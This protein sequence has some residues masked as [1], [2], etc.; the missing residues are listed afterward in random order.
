MFFHL[1]ANLASKRGSMTTLPERIQYKRELEKIHHHSRN[2][3]DLHYT[4][5]SKDN[6]FVQKTNRKVGFYL[7]LFCMLVHTWCKCHKIHSFFK[8]HFSNIP[9]KMQILLFLCIFFLHCRICLFFLK[10]YTYILFVMKSHNKDGLLIYGG[11]R[12]VRYTISYTIMR[13][14]IVSNLLL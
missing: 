12:E 13:L 1:Q 6:S 14:C 11:L 10:V 4:L 8:Y 5:R 3:A 2:K 7:I 9:L